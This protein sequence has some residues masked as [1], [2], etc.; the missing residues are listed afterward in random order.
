M[1]KS[2][3]A[4]FLDMDHTLICTMKS[5]AL[6]DVPPVYMAD[7]QSFTG[8]KYYREPYYIYKRPHLDDFLKQLSMRYSEVYVFTASEKLYADQILD[9]LD[10]DGKIFTKRWYIDS[11]T[12]STIDGNLSKNV[13]TLDVSKQDG[14]ETTTTTN[15]IN[16][17][18]F[19]LIDDKEYYMTSHM[20]NG[21]LIKGFHIDSNASN[22][23][24]LLKVLDLL[25]DLDK[26]DDVRP[27]LD[28]KFDWPRK[29]LEWVR[30]S[31]LEPSEINSDK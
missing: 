2:N 8:T 29:R 25:E 20:S 22:D 28:K 21:I 14:D 6:Q 15:R 16:P 11:L 24:S 10:P 17:K 3:L 18:R 4:I 23:D 19:V 30:N 1:K 5:S 7:L 9:N 13:L 31:T 12:P 26:E 27:L